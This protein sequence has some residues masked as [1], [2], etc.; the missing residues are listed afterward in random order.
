MTWSQLEPTP[1]WHAVREFAYQSQL[2]MVGI[3]VP[4]PV[5]MAFHS[6]GGWKASLFG[7]HHMHGPEDVRFYTKPEDHH[8]APADFVM[9]AMR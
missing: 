9:P 7:N 4:I 3:N 1:R 6:F 8:L 5:L 2:G